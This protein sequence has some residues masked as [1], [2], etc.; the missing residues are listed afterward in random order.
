MDDWYDHTM[1]ILMVIMGILMLAGIWQ[2]VREFRKGETAS[3]IIA[4]QTPNLFWFGVWGCAG[5]GIGFIGMAIYVWVR[6]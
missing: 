6:P 3:A 4:R 1:A 2:G 5:C